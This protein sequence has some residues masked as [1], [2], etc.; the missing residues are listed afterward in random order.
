MRKIIL[1][2]LLGLSLFGRTQNPADNPGALPSIIP[3]SPDIASLNRI[4]NMTTGLHTGAAN[5]SI[6]LYDLS[7]GSIKHP[8]SLSYSTNGI[9][10]NDIPSR[11]GL[12]WNLVAGGSIN[13]TVHDEEDDDP[14]M[15]H[16]TPPSFSQPNQATLDYLFYAPQEGYDT[17]LD[18]YSFAVNG[19]SGKFYFDANGIPRIADHIN[20]KIA[21]PSANTFTIT[22]AEGIVYTFG[23]AIV[24]EKTKEVKTNGNPRAYKEKKT[25]WF[26]TSITS[27]E[28]DWMNFYYSSLTIETKLGPYQ[29]VIFKTTSP[30][31]PGNPYPD[32]A[33]L[34]SGS[35]SPVQYNKI[36]YYTKYLSSIETS[37]YQIINFLYENRPDGSG[38]NRLTG[39]EVYSENDVSQLRLIKKYILEYDNYPVANDLNQRFFLKKLSDEAVNGSGQ[40]LSHQFEYNDPS[41]LGRQETLTQDYYGYSKADGN[42]VAIGNFIPRPVDYGNYIDGF[43]GVDRS[44]V[45]QYAKAGALTKVIYPTGGYEAFEYEPHTLAQFGSVT[46][47]VFSQLSVQGPGSGSSSLLTYTTQFTVASPNIRVKHITGWNTAGPP[48][49]SGSYQVPDGIHFISYLEIWNLSTN[50]MV[51]E[52]RHKL[53]ATTDGFAQLQTGVTYEL[54]L[55]VRSNSHW[56]KA[57]IYYNPS[58]QTYNYVNN[59]PVCGIRVKNIKA[60][61]PVSNR[62]NTKYYTYAAQNTPDASSGNGVMRPNFEF[63]Y[64]GGGVCHDPGVL[65]DM[66]F[67]CPGG[68][69]QV[70]SSS[71]SGSFT[72]NGSPV[73]YDTVMESD[74]PFF[75]NGMTEH[76]FSTY[77]NPQQ[78]LPLL[79]TA[80]AGASAA[81]PFPDENGKELQ[82]RVYK[83]QGTNFIMLKK[84][85]NTYV[86]GQGLSVSTLPISYIVR[87]RWSPV[88]GGNFSYSDKAS[89]YDVNSYIYLYKWRVLDNTVTTDYDENGLNPMTQT[90]SYEY[91][92]PVHLQPTKVTTTNSKNETIRQLMKYPVDFGGAVYSGMV[93]NYVIS[94]LIE[95][96][97]T[98]QVASNPAT[99]VSVVHTEYAGWTGGF[100]RPATVK[101]QNGSGALENRLLYYNYDNSANPLELSKDNGAHIAYLWNYKDMYPVA[102]VKNAASTDIAYTSFEGDANGGWTLS[103]VFATNN[104][105]TGEK[106]FSG[107]LTRSTNSGKTYLVTLWARDNNIPSVNS[108]GGTLLATHNNWKLYQWKITGASS[109]S[110]SGQVIDEVRLYPLEAEMTTYTYIPFVGITSVCDV[111]N[112]ITY[113]SYDGFNRLSLIKDADL[114]II[115]KICY[116]YAGQAETCEPGIYYNTAQSGVFTAQCGPGY[117]GNQVTFTVAA[118]T[119]S[120]TTS[121]AAANQLAQASVAAN[122][123]AYANANGVCTLVC[124]N[125]SA[126]DK[127]CI[128]GVCETGTWVCVSSVQMRG[129]WECT[130]KYCF[131]DGTYSTYSQT[132][133]NSSSCAVIFCF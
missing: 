2:A 18:E 42:S 73:A 3:P 133:F 5:V 117:G 59:V 130:Y 103:G 84:I 71:L 127:K 110:V 26:L 106:T 1:A 53:Y 81:G 102:E 9:R 69:L 60:Y 31:Y 7:A 6:P 13:R 75:A 89:G 65:G 129:T 116:T 80:I 62:I 44:P 67:P 47:S 128:N 14:N 131:S 15:T 87:K 28:G 91:N 100:Y 126:N 22:T 107:T 90:V 40:R 50:Q 111:N 112:R 79:G 34:C 115:K 114:N 98:N 99:T 66:L 124:T 121:V 68:L 93:A 82:T 8:L 43:L 11:V 97:T 41:S 45:F 132:I 20:I 35:W 55:R 48:E 123:Q 72:F 58:I 49:G 119:F 94:P 23:N 78:P 125:C 95:T 17:E 86:D 25:A 104:A 52:D 39:L 63:M 57:I 12:G 76:I 70:S 113:Y 96:T 122:G 120:S 101:L 24:Y 38:D 51:Y 10:V 105:R 19:I 4:G 32:C 30:T 37:D 16:L 33:G 88:T 108:T 109:V 36:D 56:S 74:D 118:N 46:D 64:Q 77:F 83:K 92:N 29:S 27:P 21:R 85:E 54:R 61:D